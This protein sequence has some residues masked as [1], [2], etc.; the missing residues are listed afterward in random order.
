[1]ETSMMT[2]MLYIFTIWLLSIWN[3]ANPNEKLKFSL[4]A[5]LINPQLNLNNIML[6]LETILAVQFQ[7]MLYFCQN[8][9]LWVVS[10]LQ[11]Q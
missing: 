4:Y 8:L 5:I 3:V 6:L 1:M 7:D 2:E 9:N 10:Q 11:L